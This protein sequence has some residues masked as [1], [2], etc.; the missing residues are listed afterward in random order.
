[1]SLT[2]NQLNNLRH[3]LRELA[4]IEYDDVLN[5][6]LDHYASLT[7]QKVA[8]GLS[9]QD[10]S[11]WAWAELGSGEGIQAIQSD[12]VKNIKQQIRS[13]HWLVL[14]SY[15]RWP[16]VVTTAL[17]G[18]LV[19]LVVPVLPARTALIGSF[20]ISVVPSMFLLS[21]YWNGYHRSRDTQNIVWKY[22]ERNGLLPINLF[23]IALNLTNGFVDGGSGTTR[24]L[25]QTHTSILVMVCLFSML[26]SVS[27][28]QLYRYRYVY[29]P[30]PA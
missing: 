2:E 19:Y 24:V 22:V 3:D 30:K 13:Q 20:C 14:K 10:A 23:Q 29:K 4:N 25:L 17:I 18:L 11:K 1:M 27:Y 5:E 21:G 28:V 7:E 15:F 12:Y 26:Y 6:L 8:N 16:T 9:F